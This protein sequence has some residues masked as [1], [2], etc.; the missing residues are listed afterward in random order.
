M[1]QLIGF[2]KGLKCWILRRHIYMKTEVKWCWECRE[3]YHVIALVEVVGTDE[4]S[5]NVVGPKY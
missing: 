1:I 3:C 4:K 5:P 2:F